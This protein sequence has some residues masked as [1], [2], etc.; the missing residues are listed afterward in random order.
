MNKNNFRVIIICAVLLL[1]VANTAYSLTYK[2]Y[3]AGTGIQIDANASSYQVQPGELI[4]LTV[5]CSN[6]DTWVEYEQADGSNPPEAVI[7]SSGSS[8]DMLKLPW[9]S[10]SDGRFDCPQGDDI[11]W[12]APD[13]P[14]T[15][16][17]TVEVENKN[18][19]QFAD[20]KGVREIE[21][22]VLGDKDGASN[23]GAE[24]SEA[25][26][27]DAAETAGVGVGGA[28]AYSSKEGG[29]NDGGESQEQTAEP[30]YLHNG[31]FVYKH[32]DIYI[33]TGR[34]LALE[35]T[36]TYKSQ[37]VFNGRF[38]F[39]WEINYN[40]RIEVLPQGDI[41]YFDGEGRRFRFTYVDGKS[42]LSEPDV[43][44]KLARQQDKTYTLTTKQGIKYNFDANGALTAVIDRNQNKTSLFYDYSGID[45]SSEEDIDRRGKLI[46]AVD[47]LGRAIS[48][49]Y[50]ASGRL[51]KLTDFSAR[52]I[53]YNYD[54]SGNLI[55][56]ID[57]AGNSTQYTYNQE[58]RLISIIN[59]DG[60]TYL[61]NTY[62][63]VGKVSSQKYGNDKFGF[64]YDPARGITKFT[65]RRGGIW[66]YYFDENGNTIK[67]IGPKGRKTLKTYNRNKLLS[68]ITYPKGNSV[69]YEYDARG[70]VTKITR[71][72]KAG[73]NSL[74]LITAFTY[75]AAHNRVK[76]IT[77][78]AGSMTNYDYDANGNLIRITYPKAG[79]QTPVIGLSYN[80]YGQVETLTDSKGILTKYEYESKTGYLVKVIRDYG[81]AAHVNT[82]TVFKYDDTGNIIGVMDP[83]ANAA[84][85]EYD[86]INQMT[87]AVSAA[88]FNYETRYSYDRNGNLVKLERQQDTAGK[89]WQATVY[90]YDV[91]D[92]I[93]RV[94]D[95]LAQAT[96]F[97][98]DANDNRNKVIDAETNKTEYVYEERNLLC[99]VTDALGNTTEYKY[100]DNGNLKEIKDAKGNTTAYEYD[101]FDR[102]IKTIYPDSS[103]EE[104]SYDVN[105][106]LTCKKTR[107][108]D[109]ISYS[110]DASN[111]LS[112]KA[113]P[114]NSAISYSYDSAGRLI[115]VTSYTSQVT[116]YEYD[117][118]DRVTS[119]STGDKTVRYTYDKGGNRTSLV[120]PDGTSVKYVYDEL[121]QLSRIEDQTSNDILALYSYDPLSRR[122]QVDCM[123]NTTAAYSY[124]NA[125]RLL[126]LASK[127]NNRT[128]ISAFAY[129][130]DKVG[131]RL[132]RTKTALSGVGD[133]VEG[134]GYDNIY[135]LTSVDYPA[136][137]GFEDASFVY[138]P[139]GN[140]NKVMTR[141]GAEGQGITTYKSNSLNQYTSVVCGLESDVYSYDT[142]GNLVS[143]GTWTYGYDYENRLVSAANSTTT[144]SYSYDAFGR[145]ISKSVNGQS[146]TVNYIYDGDQV[147]A[148]YDCTGKLLR[149][150][151]YGPGIDEPICLTTYTSQAATRYYYHFDGLGSVV[152]M[153]DEEGQ[154]V[155]QY[156]YDAYGNVKIYDSSH[157]LCPTSSIGNTYYFTGR[158]LDEET[159][160]Y[161]YRARMYSPGL[162]R[163]LQ[164][165]PLD[166]W[167][168]YNLY[169]YCY[170]NPVNWID[171][172]G[173]CKDKKNG[174]WPESLDYIVPGYRKYGGPSRNGPGEP[175]DLMDAAF[176]QHDAG[177]KEG[178]LDDADLKVIYNLDNLPENPEDWGEGVNVIYAEL[179]RIGAYSIFETRQVIIGIANDVEYTRNLLKSYVTK[180]IERVGESLRKE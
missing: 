43:F 77:D 11:Y 28:A 162:G 110:Y 103:F 155:E 152:Q 179:Y 22:E 125:N 3:S 66:T 159:G 177:Y 21:I 95:A 31:D 20:E 64:K 86:K 42:Y 106:N 98:Y 167:D 54:D 18:E 75:D 115:K 154:V 9:W 36:R 25:A 90:D 29:Y 138:D 50:D 149:K 107:A 178:N 140:R 146:S 83:R 127:K 60:Q 172:F 161:Y 45:P 79:A 87:K 142:N 59:A 120:Y 175:E 26:G 171:P 24:G 47:A 72:P 139:L 165:D 4:N 117:D 136:S 41:Y 134:Y 46:K 147:I 109:I 153:T 5:K 112:S 108:G 119:V 118:L 81:D 130:Y 176:E 88:P 51:V 33:P 173:L 122:A 32:R 164:A 13:E 97:A 137:Y 15:Y 49:S 8:K 53:S 85:F 133:G 56:V 128:N 14:G 73:S 57:A 157:A 123:N 92:R 82:A 116:S 61:V 17:I 38:G 63:A 19:N 100:D 12:Q 180:A 158:V 89:N 34:G 65:D 114:D 16:K 52:E 6:V 94:T 124:D 174:W 169:R 170:N 78:P 143:D 144:A 113:Y 151:V 23:G 62:D 150:Y 7:K 48:F 101:E 58:H 135:Q 141:S 84:F 93:I 96:N 67:I 30:V 76:T 80:Q 129:T 156:E 37:S 102:R 39:G 74:S 71:K 168:D 148:E 1:L 126:N 131:N 145:R 35:L 70:N 166:Y 99:K 68:S 111:R 121:N 10:C 160:L 163:F 69:H 104:Y 40:K 132:S 105:S 44:D 2:E 55:R 91:L 27:G